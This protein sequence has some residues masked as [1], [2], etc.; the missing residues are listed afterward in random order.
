MKWS[1]LK[2]IIR[3]NDQ[4][5]IVVFELPLEPGT[6]C[7]KRDSKINYRQDIMILD[8]YEIEIINKFI[9]D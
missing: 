9:G 3:D 4:E 7:I 2:M 8:K 6:F 1:Q 5:Q